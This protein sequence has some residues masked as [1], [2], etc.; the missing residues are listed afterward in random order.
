MRIL[1]ISGGSRGAVFPLVPLATAARNAGHE[2]FVGV[3][4]N[5]LPAVASA[6]LPG[7]SLTSGTM[8]QFMYQDREG[9]PAVEPDDPDEWNLFN[10]HGM[11]RLAAASLEGLVPLI[12]RWRPDVIV[13]GSLSYAAPIIAAHFKI[14]FVRHA[15]NM[16]EPA[17]ID[18]GA[19]AELAPELEKF[20]LADIPGE[21]LFIDICPPSVRPEDA[22]P[23]QSM[24]YVPYNTHKK[25]DPWMYTRPEVPRVLVSAGSR[26]TPDYELPELRALV[27]KVARLGLEMV[28]A[29][30]D[31]VA[32]LLEPLPAGVRAGWLPVDVLMRSSDLLV[33]R[34][35]G[36]TMLSAMTAGIP[37]LVIPAMPKQVGMTENLVEY[38]AAKMLLDGEDTAEAIA[39]ACQELLKEPSYLKRSQAIAQEIAQ[40]PNPSEVVDIVVALAKDKAA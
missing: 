27:E 22:I 6:G 38:G 26:V 4:E 8:P 19:T 35:G 29:V 2:V 31:E 36:N 39:G 33:H 3:T 23:A 15:L 13:G 5:T 17:N 9:N 30:P 34:G 32:S 25:L 18:L 10:G 20:G 11:G 28:I 16:G 40:L 1:F 24:R 21:D 14:P 37:Q 12:E 7:V